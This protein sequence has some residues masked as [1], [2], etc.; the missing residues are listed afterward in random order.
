MKNGKVFHGL[1]LPQQLWRGIQT[2][3]VDSKELGTILDP[4]QLAIESI[5]LELGQ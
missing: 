5:S 3:P 2:P 1:A 4:D